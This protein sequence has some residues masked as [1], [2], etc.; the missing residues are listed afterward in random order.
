MKLLALAVLALSAVGC[1]IISLDLDPDM[2]YERARV[3]VVNRSPFPISIEREGRPVMGPSGKPLM[4]GPAVGGFQF[5]N[6]KLVLTNTDGCPKPAMI[7]ITWHRGPQFP[8]RSIAF[9]TVLKPHGATDRFVFDVLDANGCGPYDW[10]RIEDVSEY[11]R[12]YG[13]S[14]YWMMDRPM[15]HNW[16][17]Q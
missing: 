14:T 11:Q 4:L 5:S 6:C 2:P 12:Y 17:R 9:H 16:A 15:E 7:T 10:V 3:T 13:P 1:S 8:D